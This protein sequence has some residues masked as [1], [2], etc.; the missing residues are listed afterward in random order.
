MKKILFVLLVFLSNF[1]LASVDRI[2]LMI[3]SDPS[4]EITIGWDQVSGSGEIVYYGTTDG[5]TD[6]NNYPNS[7][8]P[9]K[10]TNSMNMNNKFAFLNGL[11]PDTKYYFII[12][13]SE[14][15][16]QRYWFKTCPDDPTQKLSFISGGDSRSGDTQRQNSNRMVAKIRPHAVL[17][18][19]DLQNIPIGNE[20]RDWLDDWE[21]SYTSDGQII[22]LVHSLGNHED[23]GLLD[24]MQLMYDVF[25]CPSDLYYKVTFGG[26]LFSVYTLNGEILPGHTIPNNT[27]RI[28]QKLWLENQLPNDNAI[29]KSAQYHRPIVPH[30]SGKG[31]G[32]DEFNDWVQTF[33]DNGVRLVMESDAHVTK[34]TEEVRPV[35]PTASG[36][37]SDWF[38]TTGID[39]DK[40]LTFI[41]EGAWGTIRTPDDSHPMTTGM[42]SMY[43]FAW[44]TVDQC[45]IEIRTI[46]TQ[47]PNAIPEHS[48][49]DLFS[50]SAQLDGQIWKPTGLPT[51]VREIVKCQIPLVDFTANTTT[52]FA[53]DQVFFTDLSTNTPTSWSWTFGDGG[54]SSDQNPT[55]VYTATGTYTVSLTATNADGSHTETKTDYINIVVPVTPIA[56]FTVDNQTPSIG[57]QIAFTDLTGNAPTQWAWDFGDGNTSTLQNP[58]HTYNGDGIYTVTLT[59]TNSFG[60]DTEQ[61]VG[62]I[63]VNNGGN[64]SVP[65][66]SG[67]DD[68]EERRGSN[69]GSMYLNSSDLEFGNDNGNEQYVG[70]RFQ[71]INVPQGAQISN[72]KLIFHADATDFGTSQLNIYFGAEDIDDASVFTSTAYDISN[73]TLTTSQ[74]T[75]ADG[76][77]PGWT[78]GNNYDSPDLSAIVQE[79]VDRNGWQSGNSMV[80]VA[81][82]DMGE[83]SERIASSYEGGTPVILSFDW[84]IPNSPMVVFTQD[85]TEICAGE[86]IQFTDQSTNNPTSWNWNFGDGNASTEQNPSHTYQNGGTYTVSLEVANTDASNSISQFNLI[87]VNQP[88]VSL[89]SF[90]SDTVCTINNAFELPMG[91]PAGGTY[92]GNGVSGTNFDPATAGEGAHDISYSYTDTNGCENSD[93]QSIFVS[94]CLEITEAEKTIF[95]IYPNP[96]SDVITIERDNASDYNKI[97]IYDLSGKVIFDKTVIENPMQIDVSSW[98][99]GEYI[100]EFRNE[101]NQKIQQ[102]IIV[103]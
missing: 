7:V 61:K 62:Y 81:W 11:Q 93:I 84:T 102:K 33:Y 51:G 63:T 82:S 96:S 60:N 98:S 44:I 64:V 41:G 77:V 35:S 92:L 10:S 58:V 72:A 73:R 65:I 52:A 36:N 100:V 54:T 50:I 42:A 30:Y 37:S 28:A 83:S 85:A 101:S 22:P 99:K 94:G 46:D 67:N 19:G 20:I 32:E 15:T 68:A 74:V 95:S 27:K 43:Q 6:I 69:V 18:G 34:L 80:F 66:M 12:A 70:M 103:Q 29:W 16:S 25:D 71:N 39:S 56:D 55:H 79:L 1:S 75:W 97:K 53:N 9:Y 49:N 8:G 88:E 14:G 4:S 59:A 90:E 45:K 76:S 87:T 89:N 23:Y 2:R 91:T 86:S 21:L 13:D 57:Q 17:F 48:E 47:N 38:T 40:G 3:H 26:S 24:G 78:S 31:E 5:G